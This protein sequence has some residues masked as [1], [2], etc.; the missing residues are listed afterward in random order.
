VEEGGREGGLAARACGVRVK[1]VVIMCWSV[2]ALIWGSLLLIVGGFG[3]GVGGSL[4]VGPGGF[5]VSAGC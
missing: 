1:N 4:F 3:G 2:A 5:G